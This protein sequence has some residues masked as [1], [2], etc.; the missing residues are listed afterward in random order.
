MRTTKPKSPPE[1]PYYRVTTRGAR[2][3]TAEVTQKRGAIRGA[4][5]IVRIGAGTVR[6]DVH[7]V[8]AERGKERRVLIYQA[9]WNR[10]TGRVFGEEL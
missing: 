2:T 3:V 10:K 4:R 7:R 6:A 9:R 8:T 1:K 5:G